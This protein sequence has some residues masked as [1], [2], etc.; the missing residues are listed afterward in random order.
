MNFLVNRLER[1]IGMDLNGDGYIGG[2]GFMSRL[3]RATHIDFNG[4]NIIGRRPDVIY[5]YP[6]M[7][8]HVAAFPV[9]RPYTYSYTSAYRYY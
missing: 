4:D 6:A 7:Y 2:E 9:P 5:G 8:G 3:E 1:N